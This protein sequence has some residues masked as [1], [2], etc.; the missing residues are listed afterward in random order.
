MKDIELIKACKRNDYSAQMQVYNLCKKQLYNACWRIFKNRPDAEDAVHDAFIKGFQKIDQIRDD[1]HIVGWFKRI[2]INHSLD[3]IRKRKHIWT[4]DVELVDV[5]E[6]EEFD[7]VD[8]VSI[9][10][11]KE[12][13]EQL[14][15][16]Y[17][18]ILTLYL[19]EDYNHREISE[20]LD[21]KESTV[22]NQFRR[23]K[24]KLLNQLQ[25]TIS[26]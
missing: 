7:K 16:K 9:E 26:I 24:A 6:E 12:Q 15:E 8:E 17:S 4:E 13:I 14:D 5:E 19:I 2:A 21:L 1:A 20:M 22:R 11:I 23:G 10:V 3:L 25:H 18:I